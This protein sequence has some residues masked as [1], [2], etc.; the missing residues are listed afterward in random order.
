MADPK[1]IRLWHFK[2]KRVHQAHRKAGTSQRSQCPVERAVT[3]ATAET[4][5]K[6]RYAT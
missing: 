3:A 4:T 6:L 1:R 2:K 5:I